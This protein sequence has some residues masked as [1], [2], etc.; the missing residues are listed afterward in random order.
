MLVS[1]RKHLRKYKVLLLS[2]IL[3]SV[4]CAPLFG[5]ADEAIPSAGSRNPMIRVWMT[6]MNLTDRIDISLTSPYLLQS[7][8]DSHM[9]ME[10]GSQITFLLRNDTIYLHYRG[11]VQDVGASASLLRAGVG[12][13]GES[14]FY[15][16]NFPEKYL[17]DLLIDIDNGCLRPVLN[18]HVED[19]LLG[20]VPY[21]MSEAFPVEA[22]KAQAV[23]ARTYALRKQNPDRFYDVVDTTNDQ[24]FKGYLPGNARCEQAVR[25]TRGVCGFFK[26]NLAQCYYSASNGGQMELVESVWETDGDFSYYTFGEDPYDVANPES[27]VRSF[28]IMKTYK[29]D[30]PYELR[31]LLAEHLTDRISDVTAD[32]VRVDRVNEVSLG[33]PVHK[34]SKLMT[35]LLINTDVSIREKQAMIRL[36]DSDTEEVSLFLVDNTPEKTAVP[37]QTAE[38]MDQPEQSFGPYRTLEDPIVLK[39]SIFPDAEYTLGMDISGNYDNEI[40]SVVEKNDRY[41][42]EARRYGHGVGMSQRGAQQMAAEHHKT[43]RDILGFYYPGLTLKQFENQDVNFA[44]VDEVLL[45][46]AGPAATPTP[47][48]TAMPVTLKAENGQWFA[49]VTEIADDSSLNLR[50]EPNLSSEIRMRL[51][52]NQRLLVLERCPQEGWVRVRTDT[53]EGYVM[54]KYLTREP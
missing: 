43:Y 22:L 13:N 49:A 11:L 23:A 12:E 28:E 17:G 8:R 31:Q 3:I 34:G 4:V 32:H 51:Y 25:E 14:G 46:T 15:R 6:R 20:V 42:L 10:E 50:A 2:M 40:W 29:K 7:G 52:K 21:E 18:I 1:R 41:I 44:E 9:Y 5:S 53:A 37:A 45:E 27:T 35:T 36:V 54:E 39:I 26:G 24:V 19:Y 33:D 48:P 16:T 47:R 30:A 38:P